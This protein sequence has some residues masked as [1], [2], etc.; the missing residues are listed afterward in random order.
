MKKKR[1]FGAIAILAIIV[2]LLLIAGVFFLIEFDFSKLNSET[3]KTGTL[4][5][6]K[7]AEELNEIEINTSFFDVKILP[8]AE[9]EKPIV[10][11]PHSENICPSFRWEDGKLSVSV[12]D[13]RRWY[14]KLFQFNVAS[15]IIPI[16]IH[17]PHKHY[18]TLNI[19]TGSGDVSVVSALEGEDVLSFG[20]VNVETGSGDIDFGAKLVRQDEPSHAGFES[21]SG[22]IYLHGMS[23]V[24]ISV[25]TSSGDIKVSDYASAGD[26]T[27]IKLMADTG[28]I[29]VSDVSMVDGD[30]LLVKLDTGDLE[31]SDVSVGT[32]KL[33]TNTGEVEMTRVLVT[34]E[35]HVT[36]DTGDVDIERSDAKD[37]YVQTDTGDVEIELLSGKMFSVQA[38]TGDVQH[39]ASDRNGGI[40]EVKT[41]TG[42]V[43][44]TVLPQ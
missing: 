36:T 41:D 18:Q 43:E 5:Y 16:E 33:E 19:L 8:K 31:L 27:H 39:P 21:G 35:L 14:E 10:Y 32:M 20:V 37:L 2:G 25:L 34:G 22:D 12:V 11:Y 17:L 29:C 4:L 40:C 44:I 7:K 23:G 6:D 26:L 15:E 38:D 13:G 30:L 28:K 9:G 1:L 3:Y 42:D 24:P